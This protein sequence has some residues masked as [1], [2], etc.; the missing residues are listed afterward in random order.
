MLSHF[1][2]VYTYEYL[3]SSFGPLPLTVIDYHP[4]RHLNIPSRGMTSASLCTLCDSFYKQG[5]YREEPLLP[6]TY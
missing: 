4:Y 2:Y 3:Q 6:D 5:I 1:T